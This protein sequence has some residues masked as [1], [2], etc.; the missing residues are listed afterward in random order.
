MNKIIFN[1]K[2]KV[3]QPVTFKRAP[4]RL[5]AYFSAEIL[6]AR[7]DWHETFKVTKSKNL[8][9][10]LLYPAKVSFKIEGEKKSYPDD[11]KLK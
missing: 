7:K 1:K 3:K 8:Q 6:Q 9:P 11:K 4:I 5:L 10:R 2:P